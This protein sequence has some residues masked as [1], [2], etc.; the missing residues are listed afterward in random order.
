MK[1]ST[2]LFNL[3]IAV[4]AFVI[5]ILTCNGTIQLIINFTDVL[6]EIAFAGITFLIGS[7]FIANCFIPSTKSNS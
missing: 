3:L 5:F 4:T 2:I 7:I 1:I 6:A